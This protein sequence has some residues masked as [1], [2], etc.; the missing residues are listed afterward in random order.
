MKKLVPLFALACI[1]FIS[2]HN[3][4]VSISYND[5][6]NYYSMNAYFSKNKMRDVEH[7]MDRMIGRRSNM[8]F[9]N[10]RIDGNLGPKQ[11][12]QGFGPAFKTNRHAPCR[13]ANDADRQPQLGGGLSEVFPG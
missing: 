11:L 1:T 3:H 4:G 9:V 7:Y 8:T 10:T 12:Q 2:C 5:A 6:D 13:N